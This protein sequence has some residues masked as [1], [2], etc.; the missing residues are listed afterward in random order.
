MHLVSMSWESETLT[1]DVVD[2]AA[3]VPWDSVAMSLCDPVP[4]R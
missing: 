1:D 4:G 3:E 2:E